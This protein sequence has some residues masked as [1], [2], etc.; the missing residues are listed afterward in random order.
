MKA[1]AA[2]MH[3]IN[4]GVVK[5]L[6]VLRRRIGE[7]MEVEYPPMIVAT[8]VSQTMRRKVLKMTGLCMSGANL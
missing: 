4:S 2:T 3:P 8:S 1:K 6:D 7:S 5:L